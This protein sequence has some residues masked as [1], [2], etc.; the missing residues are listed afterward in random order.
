MKSAKQNSLGVNL[1][2]FVKLR[3]LNYDFE[4]EGMK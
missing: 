1:P 3:G 2:G 4:G